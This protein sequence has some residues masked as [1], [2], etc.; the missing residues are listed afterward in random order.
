MIIMMLGIWALISF[1]FWNSFWKISA[2]SFWRLYKRMWMSEMCIIW[3]IVL[4]V[5]LII[6]S[7][8][9]LFG[10]NEIISLGS[11]SDSSFT[12]PISESLFLRK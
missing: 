4:F 8:I 6:I 9:A 10:G 3:E 11:D 2:Y 1:I 5:C 12:S 7:A